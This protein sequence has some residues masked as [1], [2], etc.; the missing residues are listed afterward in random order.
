MSPKK[1][2]LKT[3]SL[4]HEIG[5]AGA[6]VRPPAI[7]GFQDAPEKYQKTINGLLKDRLI[8]GVKDPEGH[9]AISLNPHRIRDV[10]K[11]LRPFW[12]HPGLMALA[13]IAAVAVTV[14]LIA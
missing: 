3:L 7:P 2:I 1:A 10:R 13:V 6:L 14:G 12:A 5:G 8:E 4:S 11:E 9:L